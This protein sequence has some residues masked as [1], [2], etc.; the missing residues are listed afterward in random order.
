MQLADKINLAIAIATGLSV[1]MSA[2]VAAMTYAI[3]RAN[4]ATVE[5]MSA[6]IEATSR[7]YIQITPVVRPMTTAIELH[8]KN[9]GT[10]SASRLRLSLDCDYFFNAEEGQPNN[11][12][13]FSAFSKEIQMFPPG[14]ELRFLLGVGHR[15][16]ANPALCPLQFSITANYGYSHKRVEE[17][18]TIDLEPFGRSGKPTDPIAEV[19]E[20]LVAEV[21]KYRESRRADG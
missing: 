11:F 9:V 10:V 6:Q 8:V 21:K 4:R 19:L 18:T 7:P 16:L 15:I 2:I 20:D 5:A 13:N 14:A 1:V 3:V 17:T 12:K